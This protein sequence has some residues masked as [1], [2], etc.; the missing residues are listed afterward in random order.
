MCVIEFVQ[1]SHMSVSRYQDT[2]ISIL[3]K[4]VRP[5]VH[6]RFDDT[7][8][9]SGT[10]LWQDPVHSWKTV[11]VRSWLWKIYYLLDWHTSSNHAHFWVLD[12]HQSPWKFTLDIS[13]IHLLIWP[14]THSTNLTIY[15]IICWFAG[16]M[17]QTTLQPSVW[18]SKHFFL[19]ISYRLRHG[20]LYHDLGTQNFLFS[21][22]NF[23][24]INWKDF[25]KEFC[26]IIL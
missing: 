20:R 15:N 16:P 3:T 25:C 12:W 7:A 8:F 14:S 23:I 9:G 24:K 22:C 2:T 5:S 17:R 1:S 4:T 21:F 26:K 6:C 18:L 19:I 11:P 10:F 13:A